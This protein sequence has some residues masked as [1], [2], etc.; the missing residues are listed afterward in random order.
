MKRKLVILGSAL[1]AL[2]G[3]VPASAATISLGMDTNEDPA[4]MKGLGMSRDGTVII[5]IHRGYFLQRFVARL[6][7]DDGTVVTGCLTNTRVELILKGTNTVRATSALC[8]DGGLF[9]MRPVGTK[10]I[11]TP[12]RLVA[13]VAATT[14][15]GHAVGQTRSNVVRI[16][17]APHVINESTL[18]YG[19]TGKYPIQV[20]IG[21]PTVGRQ[22]V[23]VVMRYV[24]S[25]WSVLSS[26]T[27]NAEG[28]IR[29][30]VPWPNAKNQY[31][32]VFIP[33]AGTG[34]I[35]SAAFMRI[36]VEAPTTTAS[37]LRLKSI[38]GFTPASTSRSRQLA[39]LAIL[40]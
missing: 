6:V 21:A 38:A 3:A 18:F 15:A 23:V 31:A 35:A 12:Q 16:K 11:Q 2:C 29:T 33:K 30:S 36:N 40:G 20:R 27:P 24:D 9:E 28:R 39:A 8:A 1:V 7:A 26:H 25:K 37:L 13:R 22:G 14:F 4:G 5:G 10:S 32:F 17:I 34:Y 19:G